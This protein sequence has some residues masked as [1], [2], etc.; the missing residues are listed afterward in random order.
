MR[1]SYEIAEQKGF[2]LIIYIFSRSSAA[3]RIGII[4]A[5]AVAV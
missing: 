2:Y 3:Q 4:G 1:L 5:D